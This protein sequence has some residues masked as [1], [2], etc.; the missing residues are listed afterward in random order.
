MLATLVRRAV[1][2]N[3]AISEDSFRV[4]YEAWFSM[5][6]SI[7]ATYGPCLFGLRFVSKV[8]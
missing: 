1:M 4:R 5:A 7:L 8:C 2:S 6:V 3:N